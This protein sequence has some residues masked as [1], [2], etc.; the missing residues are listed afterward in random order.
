MTES[1]KIRFKKSTDTE[2]EITDSIDDVM[3]AIFD[4]KS[5]DTLKIRLDCNHEKTYIGNYSW[6]VGSIQSAEL[7]EYCDKFIKYTNE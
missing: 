7:C 1:M 3:S 6:R 5:T 2:W 4:L